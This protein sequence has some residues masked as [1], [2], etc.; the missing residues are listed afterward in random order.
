MAKKFSINLSKIKYEIEGEW[1][2]S[3]FL[4]KPDAPPTHFK[5]VNMQVEVESPEAIPPDKFKEFYTTVERICPVASL[6]GA[7][8]V[9]VNSTWTQKQT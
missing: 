1:D 2:N 7:A 3:A 9:K 4:G 5:Q 6:F 8:G